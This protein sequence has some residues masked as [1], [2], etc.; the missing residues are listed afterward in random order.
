MELKKIELDD[1]SIILKLL[2]AEFPYI[3]IDKTQLEEKIANPSFH[4]LKL[5]KENKI[6]GFIE[7]ELI[8]ESLARINALVVLPAERGKNYGKEL[9]EKA[10]HFLKREGI[11]RITLLVKE[12][13]EEAK[14]LY[15]D[16]GF[17]FVGLYQQWGTSATVEELELELEDERPDYV[18]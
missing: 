9:L 8:E 12:D 10:I 17:K 3:S 6:L 7:I 15:Y 4:L 11:K 2:K 5:T 18:T 14:K 16:V 1:I 13:N